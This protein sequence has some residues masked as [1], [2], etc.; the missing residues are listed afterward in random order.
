V[1]LPAIIEETHKRLARVQLENLPYEKVLT[2]FDRTETLF[3]LDPPYYKRKLYR[4]N[5][6]PDDFKKM[7]KLLAP[8]KAKFVLSLNDV[9]EVRTIFKEFR[10]RDIELHYTAHHSV[11]RRYKEVLITNF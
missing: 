3:Y 10:I 1:T 4:F 11:G 6:E 2:R 9:P 5:L 7:A 8:L